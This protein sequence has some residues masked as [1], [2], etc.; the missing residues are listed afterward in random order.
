M[1]RV[2]RGIALALM[3]LAFTGE[4]LWAHPGHVT[5]GGVWRTLSHAFS[6]PY[7]VAVIVALAV[8]GLA[9]VLSSRPG[10]AQRKPADR[11]SA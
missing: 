2:F 6:S 11:T 7:H 10:R 3:A 9:I 5:E 4:A 8:L 1:K